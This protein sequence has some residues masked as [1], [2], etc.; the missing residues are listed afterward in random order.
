MGNT[1]NRIVSNKWGRVCLGILYIAE[2]VPL[3]IFFIAPLFGLIEGSP[4][5][6][7]LYNPIIAIL[8]LSWIVVLI[9]GVYGLFVKDEDRSIK[10]LWI[11]L[12]HPFTYL[13]LLIVVAMLL[14]TTLNYLL[15]DVF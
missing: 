12:W 10:L 13:P 11:P 4:I 5:L 7:A 9:V 6:V 8:V 1:L 15:N 2:L 14:T 3:T